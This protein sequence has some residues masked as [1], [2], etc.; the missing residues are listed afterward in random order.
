MLAALA[1]CA[2][3]ALRP[4]DLTRWLQ[5]GAGRWTVIASGADSDAETPA[6]AV[7]DSVMQ[8]ENANPGLFFDP[9][10]SGGGRLYRVKIRVDDGSDDDFIGFVLGYQAGELTGEPADNTAAGATGARP[11]FLLIDW[12]RADQD[13]MDLGMARAGLALSQV[14]APLRESPGA[15]AHDPADGVR[16]LARA[17]TLGRSGWE[18]GRDY[19]FEIRYTSRGLTLS[20]DGIEEISYRGTLPEGGFGFYNYSQPAVTYSGVAAQRLSLL[21]WWA[22]ALLLLAAALLLAARRR[23]KAVTA[24]AAQTS[25]SPE[26]PRVCRRVKHSK[27]EPYDKETIHPRLSV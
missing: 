16:E 6:D 5:E 3:A 4:V 23:R 15:W 8:S 20:V 22:L 17:A 13:Y 24:Q 18:P 21:P 19:L 1:G 2:Y 9:S 27:D 25:R 10:D 26:P 7:R 14:T 12:K 11:D